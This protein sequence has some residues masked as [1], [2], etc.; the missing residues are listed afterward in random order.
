MDI[1][2][3]LRKKKKVHVGGKE[4]GI[5]SLYMKFTTVDVN[6]FPWGDSMVGREERGKERGLQHL[7]GNQTWHQQGGVGKE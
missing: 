7:E 4:L 2:M 3:H 5:M 6:W 1:K